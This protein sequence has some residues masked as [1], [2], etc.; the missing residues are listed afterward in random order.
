MDVIAGMTVAMND[1][2]GIKYLLADHF[3]SVV[4]VASAS[5]KITAPAAMSPKWATF[6]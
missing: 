5:R 4:A 3:G 2:S 6:A 1:G